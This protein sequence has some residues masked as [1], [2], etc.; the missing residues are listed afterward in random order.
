VEIDI[1]DSDCDGVP[2]PDDACPGD[3]G[4]PEFDGCPD[5]D[6]D[7]VADPWDACPY[8]AGLP[9]LDGC[10]DDD[11]DGVA[12][13]DDDC[14]GSILTSTVWI[15]D[16]DTGVANPVDA[17]GCTLADKIAAALRAAAAGAT[18]HGTFVSAMAGYLNGLVGDGTIDWS[19]HEAIMACVGAAD[20]TQFLP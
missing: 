20:H 18:K 14:P 17:N 2:D 7:G 12:N 4:L 19:Q 9:A 5:S 16:C 15:G 8:E 13:G 1:P 6:G 3:P 11:G 10:P